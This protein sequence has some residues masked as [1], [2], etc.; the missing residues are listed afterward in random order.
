MARDLH[1]S[2]D[3]LA[4]PSPRAGGTARRALR[5][6][7]VVSLIVASGVAGSLTWVLW[8]TGLETARA[9]DDLRSGFE[10]RIDSG[11][12]DSVDAARPV[13]RGNALAELIIPR[14]DVD[15]IVVEGTDT[16]SLK[17]GPGHYVDTAYP[18]QDRGRVGIAG[19]RTTY[20]HPF[21]NL[22]DLRVADRIT[23]RTRF[24]TFDYSVTRVFE[25]AAGESGHVLEQTE[26]PTL[27]LTTC[28]PEYSSSER[29]VVYADRLD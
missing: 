1:T 3:P 15:F 17:R 25:I 14:I 4:P 28:H 10:G 22:D 20:L 24:G 12:P 2:R 7:G 23:L 18:W 13:L 27:V 16:V 29:L 19:H 21:Q 11:D 6:L 8:G 9:Q 26:E 5:W